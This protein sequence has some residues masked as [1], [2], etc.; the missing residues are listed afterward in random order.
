MKNRKIILYLLLLVAIAVSGRVVWRRV[1]PVPA[2]ADP[3]FNSVDTGEGEVLPDYEVVAENLTIPW[4]VVF[5]P[6]GDLV[7]SERSGQLV[8]K[9]ADGAIKQLPQPALHQG[10]GGLLGLVLHPEF[11]D[12][13]FIYLYLTIG[14]AGRSVNRVVRYRLVDYELVDEKII[15][16]NLPGSRFHNGGRLVFGPPEACLDGIGCYLYI[17]TGDASEPALAQDTSSL[18]GKI[19]RLDDDGVVPADNPFGNSV[20]SYGHRNPQG[21][22]FDQ[23]GRLW[24]TEHGRSGLKSGLDEI[25]LIR[26][27]ANYGWPDS[28]GDTVLPGTVAPMLHSGDVTWAPG[29]LAYLPGVGDEGSLFFGGLRGE[30]LYQAVIEDGLVSELREHLVGEFGRLRTVLLGPDGFL[31]LTTSNRDGRGRV[32]GGDDKIIRLNPDQWLETE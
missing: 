13:R 8:I 28:E 30:T 26:V 3:A 5:L 23:Q 21:L 19:L 12:N 20:Y 27:G 9:G 22:A 31:Y 14:Q 16:D 1:S 6:E 10:E 2:V 25:N 4:D 24:S 32:R 29:S 7:V 17:A 15:I 18:A 11:E